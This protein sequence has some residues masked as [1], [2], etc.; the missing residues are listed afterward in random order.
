VSNPSTAAL[1]D[2]YSRDD[3]P[4]ASEPRAFGRAFATARQSCVASPLGV[5]GA[6]IVGVG[7]PRLLAACVAAALSAGSVVLAAPPATAGLAISACNLLR[8][9]ELSK[10]LGVRLRQYSD[11]TDSASCAWRDANTDSPTYVF[12]VLSPIPKETF[13]DIRGAGKRAPDVRLVPGLADFAVTDLSGTR[14]P[15]QCTASL[16]VVSRSLGGF[17]LDIDSDTIHITTTRL[18]GLGKKAFQRL[19]SASL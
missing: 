2:R 11:G 10:A 19:Q 13:D 6:T 4:P 14:R 17:K 1:V 15:D 7:R 5:V 18:A 3:N 9:A 8:P 12:L 16:D